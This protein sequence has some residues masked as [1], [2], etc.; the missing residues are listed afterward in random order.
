[1]GS[2]LAREL[3]SSS[4]RWLLR[5]KRRLLSI[6]FY[7]YR[8]TKNDGA[9]GGFGFF[10]LLGFFSRAF[11]PEEIV[12]RYPVAATHVFVKFMLAF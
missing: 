10:V 3:P 2:L 11:L 9:A 7:K 12:C 1:M 5:S 6:L 8:C 4:S